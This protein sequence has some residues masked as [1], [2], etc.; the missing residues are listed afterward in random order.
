MPTLHFLIN[1]VSFCSLAT[2]TVIVYISP[3]RHLFALGYLFFGYNF[4]LFSLLSKLVS[5]N[6]FTTTTGWIAVAF[7]PLLLDS[8]VYARRMRV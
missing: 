3:Q 1:C 2:A 7:Y 8:L 6:S 5:L 4:G